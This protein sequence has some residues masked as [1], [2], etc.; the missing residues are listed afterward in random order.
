MVLGGEVEGVWMTLGCC[1][2]APPDKSKLVE[3]P[4]GKDDL[5]LNLLAAGCNGVTP[6]YPHENVI[7]Q[8]WEYEDIQ[9]WQ[10]GHGQYFEY[11]DIQC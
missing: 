6:S 9:Y 8:Y 3:I 5:R 10:Y 2:G 1:L 4:F 7:S 11:G